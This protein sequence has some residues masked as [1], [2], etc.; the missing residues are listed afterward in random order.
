MARARKP[1][2]LWQCPATSLSD[3]ASNENRLHYAYKASLILSAHQFELDDKGLHWR[4]GGR[5]DTWPLPSITMVRLSYRPVSMQARRFR[6][7]IRN[8]RG[9][10]LAIFS[11]TWQTVALME[12]QDTGYRA[13]ILGLHRRLRAIDSSAEFVAGLRPWLYQTAMAILALVGLTIVGMFV[14][15]LWIGLWAGALFI[16]A[17]AALFVWQIGGFMRRNRPRRYEPDNVPDDLVP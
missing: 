8:G 15:A 16:V 3:S 11:T 14:R 1:R 13:F 4:I 12:P 7:D 17:F 9:E 5:S 2:G 10:Q 6:A